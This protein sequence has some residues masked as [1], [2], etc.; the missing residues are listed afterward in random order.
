MRA[1]VITTHLAGLIADIGPGSTCG[2]HVFLGSMSG[3][4]P[5]WIPKIEPP[6]S[7]SGLALADETAASL[8]TWNAQ[9]PALENQ[10]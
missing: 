4:I 1:T 5:S 10:A 9:A 2:R 8:Q 3:R 6:S 7:E